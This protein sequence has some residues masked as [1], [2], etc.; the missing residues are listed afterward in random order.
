MMRSTSAGAPR[1][2]SNSSSWSENRDAAGGVA[3]AVDEERRELVATEPV[4]DGAH[5]EPALERKQL[6]GF[7]RGPELGWTGQDEAEQRLWGG[8]GLDE[9]AQ[10]GE[11]GHRHVVGL[12]DPEHGFDAALLDDVD[13]RLDGLDARAAR[14]DPQDLGE[15]ADDTEQ[16]DPWRRQIQDLSPGVVERRGQRV[17]QRGLAGARRAGDHAVERAAAELG[18]ELVLGLG[19][20][21]IRERRWMRW[22]LEIERGWYWR[23]FHRSHWLS[24]LGEE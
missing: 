17:T 6:R 10:L 4:E 2:R 23:A 20:I 12:V 16:R 5:Q 7:E 22:W 9:A 18:F 13:E 21:A 19:P 3:E 1:V 11:G 14:H 15:V 24:I 8:V